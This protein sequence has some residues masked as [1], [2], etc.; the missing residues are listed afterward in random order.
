MK[1]FNKTIGTYG[2]NLA[3][4][5]LVSNEYT[6]LEKNF[7]NRY[8]EVDIICNIN[9]IIVFIEVKSRYTDSFGIPSESV[10]RSKQ[11]QIIKLS[12]YYILINKLNNINIRY[13][14]IE[15]LF[16]KINNTFSIN[17]IQD[18]FRCY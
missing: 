10:T 15:V 11:R 8:G 17:H 2:E 3:L 18:A 4:N 5:Y 13:D 14:V 9:N 6:I 16:N 12:L 7:R 1:S